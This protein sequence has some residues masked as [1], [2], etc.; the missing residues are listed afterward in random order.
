MNKKINIYVM[1]DKGKIKNPGHKFLVARR[2]KKNSKGRYVTAA[3]A[4]KF[5][6]FWPNSLV[7]SRDDL[8][9]RI[10]REILTEAGV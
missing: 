1:P 4:F 6:L 9:L 10:G 3:E 2:T 5:G 8:A 7:S